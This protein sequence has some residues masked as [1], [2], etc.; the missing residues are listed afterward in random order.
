MFPGCLA[1]RV[2]HWCV[3]GLLSDALG[4]SYCRTM[5]SH[6]RIGWPGGEQEMLE[7]VHKAGRATLE[8]VLRSMKAIGHEK[9]LWRQMVK[10]Q[11]LEG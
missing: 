7:V 3:T 9:R 10:L 5:Q 6:A 4:T 2:L 8:V 1:F 11:L